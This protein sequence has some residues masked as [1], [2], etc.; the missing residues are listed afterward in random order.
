MGAYFGLSELF[1]DGAEVVL[2]LVNAL[3]GCRHL[4]TQLL[5]RHLLL[6]DRLRALSATE[7]ENKLNALYLYDVYIEIFC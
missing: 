7:E 6:L 5:L 2:D 1:V 4:L 3:V